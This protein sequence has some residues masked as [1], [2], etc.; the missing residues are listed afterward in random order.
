[1]IEHIPTER[2]NAA[3]NNIKKVTRWGAFLQIALWHD[4]WGD[5]I[6]ARL[7]LTVEDDDWWKEKITARW[8]NAEYRNSGD[9]RLIAL[10][11]GARG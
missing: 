1:V 11:G 9:G 4:G 2:V 6:G 5:K 7:H 3:L 10:T 8:P